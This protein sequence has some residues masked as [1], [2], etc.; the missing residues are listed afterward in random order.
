MQRYDI[1]NALIRK[2]NYKNYLEIGVRDNYC[3]NKIK[4]KDKS[5]VDPMY[6]D[7][8]IKNSDNWDHSKVPVKYRMT[9]DEYFKKHKTKYDII[10]IDGLHENEQV[11][12][13]IQNS[14]KCLNKGGAILMHDCLPVKEEHQVVP[15]Q[16]NC[17]NG[18]VWKAY[19]RVRN[20][21][22]DIDMCII[23]TDTGV[24]IITFDKKEKP[25]I[26]GKVKLDWENYI[27]YKEEW[28]NIKSISELV[29]HLGE[30]N[31]KE[32]GKIHKRIQN[33]LHSGSL[34]D[35]IYSLPLIIKKGGGNI[36]IKNKN[37][38]SATDQQ[39]KSLFKLLKSQPY[40]NKVI[41]YS[42]EFGIKK[43]KKGEFGMIDTNK[44]VKYNPDIELD[45][46]LD[47]FRLSPKLREEHI[48]VF[49]F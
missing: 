8:E 42:D 35:I 30:E 34:G 47:Y 21:R 17:W 32:E 22:K 40:I 45:Y 18:D 15:R 5:G 49:L 27:K 6:D 39:Y 48:S 1:I 20:E 44:E 46:D 36:Y 29:L 33:F 25:A 24:G 41:L 37:Q 31:F 11:Y 4:I 9:S 13:D 26:K 38:F 3:F 19:V 28:M 14:L 43:E 16:T 2:N 7:W 10:F 23:D 12:R